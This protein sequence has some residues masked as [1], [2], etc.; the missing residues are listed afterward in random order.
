MIWFFFVLE[1]NAVE[2]PALKSKP[3][4][5]AARFDSVIDQTRCSRRSR[6]A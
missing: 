1:L 4:K 2:T 6:V 3:G 5:N